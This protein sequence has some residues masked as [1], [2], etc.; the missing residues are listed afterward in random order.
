MADDINITWHSVVI[1][2][3]LQLRL[4][5]HSHYLISSTA[6]LLNNICLIFSVEVVHSN[7]GEKEVL[8]SEVFI[9]SNL[10]FEKG[11]TRDF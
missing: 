4:F 7:H 1:R 11:F 10:S 9:N 3:L 5:Q 8:L 2:A 6:A